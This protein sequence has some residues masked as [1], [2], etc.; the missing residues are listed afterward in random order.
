MAKMSQQERISRYPKIWR[1]RIL[2]YGAVFWWG[3]VALVL[4]WAFFDL[5]PYQD[6]IKIGSYIVGVVFFAAA[7]TLVFLKRRD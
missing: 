4:A 6:W 2:R 3:F 1:D 7:L 5:G